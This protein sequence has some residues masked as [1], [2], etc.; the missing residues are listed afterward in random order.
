[1]LTPSLFDADRVARGV[2][3]PTGDDL[4]VG[5]AARFADPDASPRV[6][7][8]SAPPPLDGV[9][10][11]HLEPAPAQAAKGR[12]PAW[13][14]DAPAVRGL[15]TPAC[16]LAD[17][18]AMGVLQR[19]AHISITWDPAWIAAGGRVAWP[20]GVQ[21]PALRALCLIGHM[22]RAQLPW[23]A[24]GL[25][26]TE[27]PGLELL[28]L[29]IDPK[30]A[31]LA[32]MREAPRLSHLGVTYGGNGPV[33]DLLPDDLRLLRVNTLGPK[34]STEGLRRLQSLEGLALLNCRA[35]VD[36]CTLEALPRLRELS[37]WG[38]KKLAQVDALLRIPA[39]ESLELVDCGRPFTAA[40][41][42]ALAARGL[43]G[44]S[45]QFA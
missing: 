28:E 26:A 8:G 12:A 7:W 15:V 43:R 32:A 16:L 27:V 19:L 35:P 23:A 21:A 17:L 4:L 22:T 3:P 9:R 37:L 11:V 34:V 39:L 6:G 31:S 20:S 13:L 30:G 2:A 41:K 29:E 40:Q 38:T 45:I 25:S 14:A 18:A 36:C 44:L 42:A 24:L 1:V 33:V 10:W 5:A